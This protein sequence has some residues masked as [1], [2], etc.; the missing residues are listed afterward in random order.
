MGFLYIE[1]NKV[2]P[3]QGKKWY[4]RGM[5]ITLGKIL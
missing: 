2:R 3:I 5:S 1:R 4:M